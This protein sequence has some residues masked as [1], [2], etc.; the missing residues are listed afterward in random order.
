MTMKMLMTAVVLLLCTTTAAAGG[1]ERTNQVMNILFEEGHYLEVMAIYVN[2]SIS[3]NAVASLGGFDSGDMAPDYMQYS[4]AYKNDISDHLTLAFVIDQPYGADVAYPSDTNYFAQGT[5]A[6]L[7]TVAL[8]AVT[9]YETSENW[10][11]YG[12]L[13]YQVLEAKASVPFVAG[14]T[15]SGDKDGS[16]GYLVGTAYK[17]PGFK[18]RAAITYSSKISHT[19]STTENSPLGTGNTSATNVETPQSVNLD[20]RTGLATNTLLFAGIR[21][22]NW[23]DFDITPADYQSLTG[24]SLVSYQHDTTTYTIGLGLRMNE[25]WSFSGRIIYEPSHGGFT[26]NLGPRDGFLGAAIAAQ[27][28]MDH[29]E[30]SIGTSYFDVGDTQTSL[31]GMQAS[32]FNG[33]D[34]IVTGARVGYRF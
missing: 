2:R 24:S 12:G 29:T 32:T 20:F 26:P 31:G 28:K 22:V 1:I 25:R 8:T 33:N 30:I 14:Y 18:L 19:V 34:A 10:S 4:G 3:G 7:D 17:I 15:A 13:R 16:Y 9:R 6:A 11:V 27:Y 21:W 5:T 23:S